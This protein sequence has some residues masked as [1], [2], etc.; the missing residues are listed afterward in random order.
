[1]DWSTPGTDGKQ[2]CPTHP[3][4][5]RF[6]DEGCAVCLAGGPSADVI[7]LGEGESLVA[8]AESMGLPNG[9]QAESMAWS[10]Y[11]F[12]TK[13][14]EMAAERADKFFEGGDVE[15][16]LK[17]DATAA[18]WGDTAIK[19]SKQAKADTGVRERMAAKEKRDRLL[20]SLGGN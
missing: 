16:G 14:K 3:E 2:T 7:T 5:G 10:D 1:V 6:G 13:R 17:A 9:L 19:A 4:S 15:S 8:A 11:A 12:A 20:K 18:K